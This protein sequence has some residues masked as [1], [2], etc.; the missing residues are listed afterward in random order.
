MRAI[1]AG[2]VGIAFALD[3][4]RRLV[5]TLS[6]GDVRRALLRG[7]PPSGPLAPHMNPNYRS[8]GTGAGRAEVLDLMQALQL[9]QIPVVDA[10]G[11]LAGLHLIHEILGSVTRPNEAVVMAG[12][13]GTRLS[14]LTE[15]VPK[16][17]VRV[18]GRPILERIVLHLVGHGIRR[19]HLSVNYLGRLIEEHFG[20]GSRFG[21]RIEYLREDRPLGTGGSLSLLPALPGHPLVVMNGDLVTQVD[22]GAMLDYHGREGCRATVGVRPYLHTVPYGC[23]EIEGGRVKR[24]TEKPRLLQVVNA[25]V[26]VLEPDL[27]SQVPSGR[28]FPVTELLE[29]AVSRGETVGAFEIAEDWID[30]GRREDLRLANEGKS[31]A[32]GL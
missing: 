8:V 17:L 31:R 28:E 5:G 25:G 7:V 11:R 15:T 22:L 20:D 32:D 1:D 30:V 21:C 27:V 14:P 6:D 29:D 12:G 24:L 13:R 19:V 3:G 10:D 26:Y 23:L 4:E 16:P 9:D 18:A 2:G